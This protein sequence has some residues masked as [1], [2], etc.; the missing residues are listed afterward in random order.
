MQQI[1]YNLNIHQLQLVIRKYIYKGRFIQEPYIFV[2]LILIIASDF[3]LEEISI[4]IVQTC[5]YK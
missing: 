5:A 3:A 2:A 1:Y 4:A